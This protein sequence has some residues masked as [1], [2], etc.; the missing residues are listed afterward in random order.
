[1]KLLLIMAG[2]NVCTEIIH[3]NNSLTPWMMAPPDYLV[4][5][6]LVPGA[7][8]V[9]SAFWQPTSATHATNSINENSFIFS[10]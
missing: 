9:S 10:L 1:M 8:L 5:G 6:A 2:P 4:A 3:S 7:V